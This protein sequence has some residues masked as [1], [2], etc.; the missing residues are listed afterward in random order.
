MTKN[1]VIVESPAKARTVSRYLGKDFQVEASVGH[2]RDLPSK[3]MAVDIDNN[4]TP[5]Y[6]IMPGKKSIVQ[7]LKKLARNAENIYLATD[8]DREGEAISWHILESISSSK[9]PPTQRVVFHEITEQGI[10]E[11]FNNPGDIDMQLVNAQQA[12]RILDRVV[13]Y[14]LSPLLQKKFTS[15]RKLG[16]SAGRVQSVALKIIVEREREIS[17]FIPQEYWNVTIN[18]SKSDSTKTK[19][20][21]KLNSEKI[22]SESEATELKQVLNNSSYKVEKIS[23]R[24][25][26]NKA[27]APFTTSTLQQE[28]SRRLRYTATRTMRIAQQLYE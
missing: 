17:S 27:P 20:E 8:P 7:N 5:S 11:A 9:T 13:G 6:V 14:Q 26:S 3:E 2:I 25:S 23:V 28:A 18:L 22:N 24:N 21:A 4:F 12:R 15:G 16:L 1:L 19:F 10:K